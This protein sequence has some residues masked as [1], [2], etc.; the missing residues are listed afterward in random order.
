MDRRSAR[1]PFAKEP[2][3][4]AGDENRTRVLSLGSW[5]RWGEIAGIAAILG[6]VGHFRAANQSRFIKAGSSKRRSRFGLRP[7]SISMRR[8]LTQE[9]D[10]IGYTDG[11][12]KD[13]D[14]ST[15]H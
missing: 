8:V 1:S 4:R 2:S 9:V 15:V 3:Q 13:D 7:A 6:S 12:Y 10:E 14:S 5:R 11:A